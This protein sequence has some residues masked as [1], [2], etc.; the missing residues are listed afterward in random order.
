MHPSHDQ[1]QRHVI[2]EHLPFISALCKLERA[3]LFS[4][5]DD[6]ADTKENIVTAVVSP[7]IKIVLPA[8]PLTGEA[9][10]KIERQL[11]RCMRTATRLE[12]E[13]ARPQFATKVPPHVQNQMRY[14]HIHYYF[15]WQS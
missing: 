2:S 11:E 14:L 9:L 12:T 5:W 3:E 7:S 13:F 4:A 10:R 15:F 1:R 8:A 6:G